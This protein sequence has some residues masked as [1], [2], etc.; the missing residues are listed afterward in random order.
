[1]RYLAKAL[2]LLAIWHPALAADITIIPGDT[3]F[4]NPTNPGK[5]YQDLV[6][7]TV[8]ISTAAGESFS[9]EALRIDLV[10]GG[11]VGLSKSVTC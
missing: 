7:H 4:M 10:A 5:H 8:L 1:M 9:L 11:E 2:A 6:L 3:L